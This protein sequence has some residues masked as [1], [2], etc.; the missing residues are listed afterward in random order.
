MSAEILRW[1]KKLRAVHPEKSLMVEKYKR[2][3]NKN[4]RR[5]KPIRLASDL[6]CNQQPAVLGKTTHG[7]VSIIH[8]ITGHAARMM[9]RWSIRFLS[10]TR[11][12]DRE[13]S[14]IQDGPTFL[15]LT[16]QIFDHIASANFL[17][18]IS[19]HVCHYECDACI[20]SVYSD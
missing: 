15:K 7:K 20:R 14:Y 16:W 6:A 12:S 5:E 11:P 18:D 19:Y 8:R 13:T 17:Q 9:V 4:M 2:G 10:H 1:L 3:I